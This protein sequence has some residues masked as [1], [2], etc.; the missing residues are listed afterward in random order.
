MSELKNLQVLLTEL[1]KIDKSTEKKVTITQ[2]TLKLLISL[3]EDTNKH[4][5]RISHNITPIS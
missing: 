1:D 3:M 4:M 2:D 5:E